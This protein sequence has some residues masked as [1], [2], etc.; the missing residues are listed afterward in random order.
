MK[1]AAARG[2]VDV[3][4]ILIFQT[5]R[6]KGQFGEA[7]A[8]AFVLFGIILALSQ[9]QNRVGERMVFYG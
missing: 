8:M 4:S 3:A 6:A 5:F 1:E 9:I 2:T 7:A